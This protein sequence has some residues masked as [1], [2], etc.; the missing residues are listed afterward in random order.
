VPLRGR[1]KPQFF[2]LHTPVYYTKEFGF[3]RLA[4]IIQKKI[5]YFTTPQIAKEKKNMYL[6]N[7]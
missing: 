4:I 7:V 6:L 1:F 2:A 5:Y 3:D